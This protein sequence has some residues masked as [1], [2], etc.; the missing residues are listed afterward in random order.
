MER[1]EL[2]RDAGDYAIQHIVLVFPEPEGDIAILPMLD[3]DGSKAARLEQPRS[4]SR[5]G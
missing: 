1:E 3:V 4:L 2:A 5:T